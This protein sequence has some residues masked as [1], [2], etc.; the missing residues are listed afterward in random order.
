MEVFTE[1]RMLEMFGITN[2]NHYPVSDFTMY[3]WYLQDRSTGAYTVWFSI[4][5]LE[6]MVPGEVLEKED[7]YRG[8]GHTIILMYSPKIDGFCFGVFDSLNELRK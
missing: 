3:K 2:D 5:E 8:K 7:V 4:P 6:A 1:D